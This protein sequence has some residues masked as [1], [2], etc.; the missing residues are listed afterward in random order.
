[1]SESVSMYVSILNILIYIHIHI[2]TDYSS[3]KAATDMRGGSKS[4][5]KAKDSTVQ[6]HNKKIGM[7]MYVCICVCIC[8][9]VYI[10][11]CVL[12]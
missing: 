6:I 11:V 2:H 9:C 4:T 5:Y 12:W 8:M 10:C 7:C 1:M 3:I